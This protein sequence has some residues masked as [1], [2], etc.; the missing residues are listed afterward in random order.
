[1]DCRCSTANG[2]TAVGAGL[3]S[4][5]RSRL[6]SPT[7]RIDGR[8]VEPG[9]N[10]REGFRSQVSAGPAGLEPAQPQPEGTVPQPLGE[11]RCFLQQHPGELV[12]DP[13]RRRAAV[14]Q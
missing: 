12:A 14:G 2:R 11:L 7:V 4:C 13:V 9:T 3:A 5:W 8:D 1:M 6:T 10:K